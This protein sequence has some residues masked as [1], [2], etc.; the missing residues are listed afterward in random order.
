MSDSSW[1][2][3]IARLRKRFAVAADS[4]IAEKMTEKIN[5]TESAN[6][7]RL[8]KEDPYDKHRAALTAAR[9]DFRSGNFGLPSIRSDLDAY[10]AFAK[11][12]G[13][14]ADESFWAEN[15]AEVE[16]QD[17][18]VVRW[19][20]I[21][22]KLT[23]AGKVK[24]LPAD[25]GEKAETD[26][27]TL[28][29]LLQERWQKLLDEKHAEWE[30]E[31]IAEWR[32]QL[33]SALEEWLKLLQQFADV[34]RQLSLTPGRL[35][36]LSKDGLSFSDI[37]EMKRWAKYLEEDESARK[38]CE[39]L[40][41]M[42]AAARAKREEWIRTTT[43]VAEMH[44]DI[45]SR[46]EIV[47]VCSGNNIEYALA[48]EKALLADE[49]TA[50]LFYLKF[51][52]NRLLQFEMHGFATAEVAAE[53]NMLTEVEEKEKMGPMIICVDTSGSMHGAPET[54]AKAATLH[55]A[56][57][58]VA[59]NRAC[60]LIN[61]ST[62]IKTLDLSGGMSLRQLIDFL[63]ES[64]HGGTDVAPAVAHTLET[65][66]EKNYKKADALIISDF[67]MDELPADM[68]A[69]AAAAKENGN[70]FYA[71]TI[72]EAFVKSAPGDLFEREW[73]YN[74]GT[75]GI[76]ELLDIADAT[77]QKEGAGV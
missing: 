65:M 45:H 75:G 63:R 55:L 41:R 66:K 60:Y 5:E 56:S 32:R 29:G 13:A 54:V 73:V 77:G 20:N 8:I 46:E 22:D 1:K 64:F 50:E 27:K 7:L 70:K 12:A 36:D 62:G 58:A 57:K 38:L 40:G 52:E 24:K 4:E 69:A 30:M 68:L 61:F 53:K 33:F 76:R 47:G 9:V 26:K 23:K 31:K 49:E 6:R 42:R 37:E 51:A 43:T 48:A 19:R 21:A 72:G 67:L 3:M 25:I 17:R 16:K 28:R 71:L 59:E 18:Q 44:P 2:E 14:R 10:K 74:P 11:K 15:V 35:F 39:M 34:M